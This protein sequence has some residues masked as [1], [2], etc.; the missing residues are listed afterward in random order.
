MRSVKK[1]HMRSVCVWLCICLCALPLLEALA[2]DTAVPLPTPTPM[3]EGDLLTTS[4]AAP[5]RIPN[6]PSP[7]PGRRRRLPPNPP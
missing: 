7:Q 6:R 1:R 5:G 4:K 2:E 3:P